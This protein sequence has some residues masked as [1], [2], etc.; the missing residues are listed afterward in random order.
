VGYR[1]RYYLG[2]DI[3]EDQM[4]WACGTYG[5]DENLCKYLDGI[6]KVIAGVA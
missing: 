6:F 3:K 2:D 5:K 1:N 4:G